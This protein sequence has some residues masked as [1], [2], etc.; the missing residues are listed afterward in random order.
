MLVCCGACCGLIYIGMEEEEKQIQAMFEDHP[1]VLEEIGD[2]QSVRRDWSASME[3]DDDSIWYFNVEGDRA[4]GVIVIKEVP[5]NFDSEELE[6][7]WATLQLDS[8]EE[9]DI[10]P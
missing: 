2:I 7:E 9:F 5:F 8:G 6:I 3:E 10:Y 1:I 4:D